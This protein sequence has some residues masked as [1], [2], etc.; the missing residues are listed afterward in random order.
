MQFYSFVFMSRKWNVDKPRMTH[1]LQKLKK[2]HK[3]PDG[4]EQLDPMWLLIFPEGTN[5][6]DN[7]R[8][9][10][11]AWAEKSGIQDVR[12]LLLPRSTGLQFCL[13]ELH[14]TVDYIYDCTIAYE[15]IGRDEYAQDVF[16]L[17]DLYLQGLGPKS[18][19]LH[20][21]RFAVSSIPFNDA[22][23]FHSWVLDRWREKDDMLEEYLNTG[24]LPADDVQDEATMNG[25]APEA[26]TM[27]RSKG[28]Y[29]ETEVKPVNRFEFLQMYLPWLALALVLN[30][31]LKSWRMLK[32][33]LT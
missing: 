31:I 2:T 1:R 20:W 24:R 18:I 30:V 10:S 22:E 15:G 4:K 7:Q 27:S 12:H 9:K 16:T 11:K 21:R 26:T 28:R 32:A 17:R 33:I 8:N 3:S 13:Q 14:E 29:I 19:N 5:L 25:H 6:S 23:K